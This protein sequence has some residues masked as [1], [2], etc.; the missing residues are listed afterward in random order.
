MCGEE[1][2]NDLFIFGFCD[3][4]GGIDQYAA[5]FYGS[6]RSFENPVL[7]FG[8]CG[9]FFEGFISDFRFSADDA[10]AGTG[11]VTQH[12][13]CHRAVGRGF[14]GIPDLCGDTAEMK[15][16][17]AVADE[18]YTIL[19]EI[20]GKDS[21]AVLHPLRDRK[22]FSARC[23]T[24]IQNGFIGLGVERETAKLGG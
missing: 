5:G 8:E 16:F 22:G 13:I 11:Y 10:E 2:G 4:T 21:A 9:S 14:C 17:C 7:D 18:L 23:G 19:V 15:A 3:G 1:S 6:R 24:D 12:T 20:I